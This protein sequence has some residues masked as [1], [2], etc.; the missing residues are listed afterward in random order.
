MAQKKR[1]GKSLRQRVKIRNKRGLHAR[2]AA[3]FVRCA[4]RFDSEVIVT[5]GGIVVPGLSIMG[6]LTRAASQG[7]VIEIRAEGREAKVA[8]EFLCALVRDGFE[9]D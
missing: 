6:L 5:R 3:K 2:A 7:T 4:A 9:E 8:L 1:T